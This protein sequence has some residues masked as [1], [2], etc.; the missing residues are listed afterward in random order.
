MHEVMQDDGDE[1]EME[2]EMES[3][4]VDLERGHRARA[5][6]RQSTREGKLSKLNTMSDDGQGSATSTNAD[7]MGEVL[8]G[9]V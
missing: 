3:K 4:G 8:Q 5:H 6:L 9:K 2:M 7:V 1:D